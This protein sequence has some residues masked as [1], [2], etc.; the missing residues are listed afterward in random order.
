MSL[1][2]LP[3][4]GAA[5]FLALFAAAL[6]KSIPDVLGTAAPFQGSGGTTRWGASAADDVHPAPLLR[7]IVGWLSLYCAFL[8]FQSATKFRAHSL[9]RDA[10]QAS[11]GKSPSF[12]E[13]KYGSAGNKHG[14]LVGDRTVGNMLE[15]SAPFLTGLV[16]HAVLVSVD[17]ASQL[18]WC[19]LLS[20]L[21]YPVCFSRGIPL[22]FVSTMP[23]YA[24]IA[25]L[26]RPVIALAL[27]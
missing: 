11:D 6:A 18:G 9:L 24:C 12:V 14:A 7:V 10:A 2:P 8:F 23:G 25:M 19:W 1:F 15:Q 26:W 20:R 13:V 5:L 27:A 3:A 17:S 22:L 16:L 4:S 21:I